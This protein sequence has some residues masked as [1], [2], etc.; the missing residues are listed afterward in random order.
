MMHGMVAFKCKS[1]LEAAG[2]ES[3][4]AMFAGG[5][6]AY[7]W[8]SGAAAQNWMG[9]FI[10]PKI[11]G[12]ALFHALGEINVSAKGVVLDHHAADT[13]SEIAG[14][15]PAGCLDGGDHLLRYLGAPTYDIEVALGW[16]KA[17][18]KPEIEDVMMAAETHT[19]LI[20]Q[21]RP[22][23]RAI[24]ACDDNPAY[25]F[26]LPLTCLTWTVNTD[27]VPTVMLV[28]TP[29]AWHA[30][31]FKSWVAKQCLRAGADVYW[32]GDYG[33]KSSTVA[34]VSRLYAFE[35][36]PEAD[37]LL[38]SD[39]DMWVFN[40][41][42]F[43]AGIEFDISG[44]D[45]YS[46]DAYEH[47]GLLRQPICYLGGSAE[48]WKGLMGDTLEDTLAKVDPDPKK[49][50]MTDEDL[51]GA[52]LRAWGG[53]TWDRGRQPQF[54]RTVPGGYANQR[55]ERQNFDIADLGGAI[56][57]HMRRN[58]WEVASWGQYT[59]IME[60]ALPDVWPAWKHLRDEYLDLFGHPDAV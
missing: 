40:K 9:E 39:A 29:E 31:P 55:V 4:E 2:I 13:R 45:L 43:G 50:W 25:A 19:G 53:E 38:T 42:Y 49:A 51:I 34:Q 47:E 57:A 27:L 14:E 7:D 36:F 44:F 52:R 58:G 59:A 33:A 8:S 30:D 18:G 5:P 56:D 3:W 41:A 16:Y 46:Q 60:R 20:R 11:K 35:L 21:D 54:W 17:H 22:R 24:L 12:R 28:G 1:F 10:W 15:L 32:L 23:R 6:D 48:T 37:Y 26:T